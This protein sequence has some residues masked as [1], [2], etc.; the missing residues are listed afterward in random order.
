MAESPT[1]EELVQKIN[2]LEK[3]IKKN[4][5]HMAELKEC[6]AIK[7]A[8]FNRIRDCVF[9]SDIYGNFLDANDTAL[10]LLGYERS[11]MPHLNFV[12]LINP[13]D[14]AFVFNHTQRII[15][16]GYQDELI[17]LE[18]T[19]KDG[20]KLTVETI[21][22]AIVMDDKT[23]AILGIARDISERK[24]AD[25][26]LQQSE[27]K[28]RTLSEQS[29]MAIAIYQKRHITYANQA[30]MD[31]LGY[32]RKEVGTW[33]RTAILNIIHP[34]DRNFVIAEGKKENIRKPG[35]TS[36]FVFRV[37]TK[38]GVVKWIDQYS[39]VIIYGNRPA[40]FFTAID[41]TKRIAA[42]TALKEGE[43]MHRLVTEHAT[44][45]IWVRET[46]ET[47]R[48][49]PVT[50]I[51][52]S[53]E[54]LRGF[55]VEEAKNLKLEESL[56]PESI[57]TSLQAIHEELQKS[58]FQKADKSR[59][60]TIEMEMYCKDGSKKWFELT[61]RVIR[62]DAGIPRQ[63]LGISRDISERRELQK[64]ALEASKMAS[65]GA[66]VA[67]VAHEINT[68]IGVSITAST[69]MNDIVDNLTKLVADQTATPEKITHMVN[70]IKDTSAIILRN[71]Q[72][73]VEIISS[74]K[75]VAV[76]QSNEGWR[77][78]NLR[79][80]IEEILINLEPRLRKTNYRITIRCDEKYQLFSSP[81][82]FF[83]IISNLVMNSLMHGFEDISDGHILIDVTDKGSEFVLLYSDDGKGMDESILE[84]LFDP[85][86]TTKRGKGGTGLGL[87]I[88]YNLVTQTLGG[89]I[90]CT[91]TPG[92]GADFTLSIPA[93]HS[94]MDN[95]PSPT[96]P[97]L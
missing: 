14:V 78:F 29:L 9:I 24:K 21:N 26:A 70:K 35:A 1:Y 16:T 36:H 60:R 58:F 6:R 54:R 91:S 38:Q 53:I 42:E 94:I 56:P 95:N 48:I 46:D 66:L 88:V 34:D 28:F 30:F 92:K 51:S 85:F 3:K 8:L 83:Q 96:R 7:Q 13:E 71:L 63:L 10:D 69:Y 84:R 72:H 11:D 5:S 68:P 32:T 47:L 97:D 49:G 76:D 31:I 80:T 74:F 86:F 73:A 77:W 20:D 41:I 43:E 12:N 87:H 90:V 61:I 55:T 67:G 4:N 59:S 93:S 65:L 25:I 57:A 18:L 33:D 2:T 19:K 17:E 37:I 27:E 50:F 82:A 39:K 44:D 64:Q 45:I 22:S 23:Y 79:K 75:Q 81:G 40:N 62:D 15:E 52:P 89:R